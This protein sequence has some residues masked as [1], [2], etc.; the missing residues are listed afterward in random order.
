MPL[1]SY[2]SEHLGFEPGVPRAENRFF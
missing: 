1:Y 2:V